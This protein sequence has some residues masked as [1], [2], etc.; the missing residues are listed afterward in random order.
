MQ[1][2]K[3]EDNAADV[4]EFERLRAHFDSY[5]KVEDPSMS[6]SRSSKL[7]R[8]VPSLAKDPQFGSQTKFP[9]RSAVRDEK[10]PSHQALMTWD[11]GRDQKNFKETQQDLEDGKPLGHLGRKDQTR[12]DTLQVQHNDS[13]VS[14]LAQRWT[15]QADQSPLLRDL[16]PCRTPLR[17]KQTKRCPA[18]RHI[19]VRPDTKP[20]SHK[21]KIRLLAL[22]HLPDI[23]V[24][25]PSRTTSLEERRRNGTLSNLNRRRH[26][27]IGADSL[28]AGRTYLFEA[29]FFNPLDE[30]LTIKL[31]LASPAPTPNALHTPVNSPAKRDS[32]R[33]PW[34]VTPTASSFPVGPFNAVWE[35]EEEDNELLNPTGHSTGNAESSD[36][37][38]DDSDDDI[39]MLADDREHKRSRVDLKGSREGRKRVHGILRRKGHETV[40]GIELV[41]GKE[42]QGD[43]EVS[44]TR[45]SS[46][47]LIVT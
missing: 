9:R 14:S 8:D 4:I 13:N 32:V 37:E 1:L 17:T 47:P 23:Q 30:P 43:I 25:L 40:I 22:N 3:Q 39:D 45:P 44:S 24:R 28:Q 6:N 10:I 5:L 27:P 36:S 46:F 26:A 20:T 19:I 42:A 2:Q 31:H 33:R 12:Y 16:G 21:Y 11:E 15:S 35:L 38:V 29:S 34:S 7:L 18:C 41:V